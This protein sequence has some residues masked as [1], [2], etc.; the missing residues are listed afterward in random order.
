MEH[1]RGSVLFLPLI[2]GLVLGSLAGALM[3]CLGFRHNPQ[4]EFYVPETW[5]IQWSSAAVLFLSWTLPV[6]GIV[7]LIELIVHHAVRFVGSQ[8]GGNGD[9]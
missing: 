4:G 1:R 3:L 2:D 7:F 5:D 6:G 8:R 9:E